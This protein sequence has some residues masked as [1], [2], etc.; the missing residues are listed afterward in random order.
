MYIAALADIHGNIFAFEAALAEAKRLGVDQVVI[1]GDVVVASPDS[2]EC[3]ERVKALGCPVIRGNHERYVFDLGTER[4][5]PEWRTRRFGPVHYVA[6][7]L[8]PAR[9]AELAALPA[10]LRL[11]EA[12]GIFF[13]HGSARNDTDL[14]FPYTA[15]EEIDP[16]FAGCSEEWLLRGHNHFAG[17]RLWR[18]RKVVTVGSVGLPLDGRP[19]AQFTTLRKRGDLWDVQ[20]RIASYDID[21]A[22]R[23]FRETDYLDRAGPMA[24]LY[25]REVKSG[26]FQVIPFFSFFEAAKR[27][28]PTVTFESAVQRF[29]GE[30]W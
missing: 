5:A 7:T 12:S 6:E 18:G 16:M 23:R 4:A 14:V 30:D 9:V 3:W 8:G 25:M 1:L 13:S 17:V 22:V 11:S 19:G 21:A 24:R 10:T 29:C 27:A 26:A 2:L 28:D 15:D 20:H